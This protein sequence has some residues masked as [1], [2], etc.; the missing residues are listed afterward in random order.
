[1]QIHI[2]VKTGP[3]VLWN[4]KTGITFL[5]GDPT[6]TTSTAAAAASAEGSLTSTGFAAGGQQVYDPQA[7]AWYAQQQYQQNSE[8]GAY[9]QYY[10][11]QHYAQQVQ[12]QQMQQQQYAQTAYN[13]QVSG[14]CG[15]LACPA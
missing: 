4:S 9:Q 3:S 2:C 14:G 6:A 15:T 1:M 5:Q 8:Q 12:Q 11:Q 10:A 7:A 13:A